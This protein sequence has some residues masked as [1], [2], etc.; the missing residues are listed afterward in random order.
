MYSTVPT[1]APARVSAT[2]LLRDLASPKSISL[3]RPSEV[4]RM[5]SGFKSRWTMPV[6][7]TAPSAAVTSMNTRISASVLGRVAITSF[8]S[9]PRTYSIT[10]NGMPSSSPKPS[11][12]TTH[13]CWMRSSD[14][15]SRRSR[16]PPCCA[17]ASCKRFRAT[18]SPLISSRTRLTRPIAPA[19]RS[20]TGVNRVPSSTA[21]GLA[22]W[23]LGCSEAVSEA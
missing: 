8:R 2:V 4:T 6:A 10:K 13:S 15:N 21:I 16:A 11:T 3:A 1:T 12:L 17:M 23:H 9:D 22:L 7:C 5:F 18:N 19:P 20:L 14:L